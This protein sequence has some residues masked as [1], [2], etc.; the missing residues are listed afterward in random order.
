MDERELG[1]D[2][3]IVNEG[4]EYEPLPEGD[5]DFEVVKVERA[6][7]KDNTANGGLPACNMAKVTFRL[8]AADGTTRERTENFILHSKMEWKLSQLFLSV[9]LKKRGEPLR[10][11]WTAL[12]TKRGRCHVI[13]TTFKKKDGSDGKGN[14]IKKLYAYDEVPDTNSQTRT[15]FSQP[16]TNNSYQ[17]TQGSSPTNNSGSRAW[18]PGKFC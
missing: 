3:E 14:E 9:G 10:M 6:R 16:Q 17:R 11:N 4:G 5:Y 8:I 15:G 7:S 12:P 2:D 13:V 1:W 18:T